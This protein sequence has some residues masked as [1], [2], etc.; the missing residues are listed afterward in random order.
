MPRKEKKIESERG[1]K[2][3]NRLVITD[4]ALVHIGFKVARGIYSC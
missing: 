3:K 4:F 2:E 1:E